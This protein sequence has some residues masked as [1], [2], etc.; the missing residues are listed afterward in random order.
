MQSSVQEIP[1]QTPEESTK[2]WFGTWSFHIIIIIIMLYY[3]LNV[4]SL[5]F[6]ALFKRIQMKF[7]FNI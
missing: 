6:Q 4:I 2:S 3:M 7:W 5:M 1:Q